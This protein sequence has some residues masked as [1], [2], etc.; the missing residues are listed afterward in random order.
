MF[1]RRKQ[2]PK[3]SWWPVQKITKN[4]CRIMLYFSSSISST[5]IRCIWSSSGQ[6]HLWCHSFDLRNP[7]QT[8][9]QVISTNKTLVLDLTSLSNAVC[10]SSPEVDRAFP[11]RPCST[12]FHRV[13][14]GPR[15]VVWPAKTQYLERRNRAR[16]GGW[17]A[18]GTCTTPSR[19]RS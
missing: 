10:Q 17:N 7:L 8:Q 3:N 12:S 9:V 18:R 2:R 14:Q 15:T 1:A 19:F 4:R 5:S 13:A 6:Y 11:A 16:H